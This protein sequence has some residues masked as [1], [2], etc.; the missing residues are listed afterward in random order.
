M[1]ATAG[2]ISRL[3]NVVEGGTA[4]TRLPARI[5]FSSFNARTHSGTVAQAVTVT[6]TDHGTDGDGQGVG[7]WLHAMSVRVDTS[8]VP[9]AAAT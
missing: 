6:V 1:A 3:R 8:T 5:Q 9:A 4:G 2:N 7:S